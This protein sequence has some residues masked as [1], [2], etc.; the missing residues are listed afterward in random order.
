MIHVRSRTR[1][2]SYMSQDSLFVIDMDAHGKPACPAGLPELAYAV[3]RGCLSEIR[4]SK[5]PIHAARHYQYASGYLQ[6]LRDVEAIDQFGFRQLHAQL[7]GEWTEWA[8]S[9][10]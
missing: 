1:L 5:K 9:H 10:P 6:A 7:I 2:V 3:W 4:A 8:D